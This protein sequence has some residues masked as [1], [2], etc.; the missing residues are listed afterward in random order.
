[1]MDAL[2]PQIAEWFV[3]AKSRE[4]DEY[5]QH[6]SPVGARALPAAV[7][8]LRW[9]GHGGRSPETPLRPLAVASDP[10]EFDASL[11]AGPSS[12]LPTAL[13]RPSR[14]SRM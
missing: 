8:S 7:L 5:R 6:V 11:G 14:I 9:L 4:W 3:D 10:W 12:G 13:Y 1:M 2:G